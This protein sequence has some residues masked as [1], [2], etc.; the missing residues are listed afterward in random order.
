MEESLKFVIELGKKLETILPYIEK[1]AVS[2]IVKWAKEDISEME[3]IKKELIEKGMWK[4][5][6]LLKNKTDYKIKKKSNIEQN[7]IG[8]YK[9]IWD[10]LE[11]WRSIYIKICIL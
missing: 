8:I 6:N 2:K 1:S 4:K 11:E 3:K 9:I 5:A 10:E 7:L